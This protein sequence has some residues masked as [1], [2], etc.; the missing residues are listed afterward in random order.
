M[1]FLKY[2]TEEN[3]VSKALALPEPKVGGSYPDEKVKRYLDLI[4]QALNAMKK[5]EENDTNDAIV[6]DLRDKK[7]KWS[8]VDKETKPIKV[9]KEEPVEPPPE[10]E[11]QQEPPPPEEER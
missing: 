10:E 9:K 6:Q 1:K 7:K 11:P 2:I 5:K 8:N 3:V 4:D